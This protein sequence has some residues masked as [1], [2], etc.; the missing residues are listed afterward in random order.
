M[1]ANDYRLWS[2]IT[3]TSP[4]SGIMFGEMPGQGVDVGDEVRKAA[5]AVKDVAS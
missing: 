4:M 1:D 2:M 3:D 5:D